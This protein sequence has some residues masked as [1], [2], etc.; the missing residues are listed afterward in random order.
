[1][2][3][4]RQIAQRLRRVAAAVDEK[5]RW[6]VRPTSKLEPFRSRYEPVASDRESHGCLIAQP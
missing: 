1:M 5:N 6:S 3:I 4:F 2:E